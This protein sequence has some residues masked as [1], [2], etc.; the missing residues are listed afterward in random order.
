MLLAFLNGLYLGL[1]LVMPIGPLNLYIF[2]NASL[3]KQ[4]RSILPVV[5]VSSV[6]DMSVVLFAVCGVN[7]LTEIAWLKP[8]IMAVGIVFLSYMGITTWNT[9][10]RPL[11]AAGVGVQSYTT[12]IAYA[13][14]LSLF[15][16][17]TFIDAFMV[18]GAVSATMAGYEKHAFTAG[19]MLIDTL[20]FFFLGTFGFYLYKFSSGKKIFLYINKISALIMIGIAI[21]LFLEFAREYLLTF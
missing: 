11:E 2:N 6:C 19:C 17:H 3:H 9:P 12:Q 10:P 8:V 1:G 18:I 7:I 14:S 4:Y 5:L 13:A 16:P 20:W 15:N 21:Q